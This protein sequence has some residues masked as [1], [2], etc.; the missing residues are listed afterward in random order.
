[1]HIAVTPRRAAADQRASPSTEG[2]TG[3]ES[4]RLNSEAPTLRWWT[5]GRV[6]GGY[7]FLRGEEGCDWESR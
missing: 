4:L 3:N 1:M 5:S 2:F 7:V 6:R